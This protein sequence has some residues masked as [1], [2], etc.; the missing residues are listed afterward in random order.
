MSSSRPMALG[1]RLASRM[2]RRISTAADA[3]RVACPSPWKRNSSASPPNLRSIPPRPSAT[4][5]I[6]PNTSF[7]VSTSASAPTRP[8][9]T[10][11]SVSAVN[12]EM[13]AKHNV[14]ID[15]PCAG[16]V[17]VTRHRRPR[18]QARVDRCPTRRVGPTPLP[19]HP[20]WHL[21]PGSPR[22]NAVSQ[23][24]SGTTLRSAA[25]TTRPA[26]SLGWAHHPVADEDR[27]AASPYRARSMASTAR[28]C[29]PTMCTGRISLIARRGTPVHRVA[30][31]A[32]RREAKR[33]AL[34]Q[35][36]TRTTAMKPRRSPTRVTI[37]RNMTTPAA[38]DA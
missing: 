7:S 32:D 37:G 18:G 27:P 23:R 17:S 12:P 36:A 29:A 3:A 9:R 15:E 19:L 25:T 1:V 21:R 11:R 13:S 38:I 34:R 2:L 26:L 28:R 35:R 30:T 4:S 14:P 31:T 5:S 33:A 24:R 6:A 10:S 22:V 16:S 20:S 8:W